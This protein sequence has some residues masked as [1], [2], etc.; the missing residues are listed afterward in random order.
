MTMTSRCSGFAAVSIA[1]LLTAS[2]AGFSAQQDPGSLIRIGDSDLGGVVTSK[3]GPEAGVWVIAETTDLPTK[4]VKI[5]VTDDQGRYVLPELPKANYSVWVRGYGLVD[6]TKAQTAPGRIVNLTAAAAP[7]PAAAA[8]YYPAI[9][10]Y[11]LLKIPDKSVFSGTGSNSNGAPAALKS[12]EQW[13]DIVKTDGCFTCHQIGD[14][15]TRTIPKELGHFES[16]QAAWERRIQSGQAS[17]AMVNAISRLDSNRALA[18]FADWTDRIAA[19]ELP[20]AQPQRPQG[21]ERNVVIS[22]WDWATPT[23][24]LHDEISTD[25]RNPTVNANGPLYGSPEESTDYAP[26]LDPAQNSASQVK[27]PI[28]D[29]NTPSTVDD[30]ILAPS[31]YWGGEPIWNSQANAHNPMFDELGRVWFTSRI[32]PPSNPAFCKEGSG[33]PSAKLFPLESSGRQAAVYDPKTKKFTLIDTCFST[34]HLQFAQD[35][36]NTLW[37]SSGGGG[38]V[39]GWLNRR[40]FDETGD[41]AKSQGWTAL[42]LDANGNG[43][44]DD[45]VEPGEPV[46]PTKDKRIAAAFYGIAPSPADGSVWGSVVGFPGAVA[47]LDLGSDPPATTL[48]EYY[49]LP[50]NDPRAPVHGYSPRGMDIDSNGVVWASLASGHLASFDRRKCKGPLNGPAA[51]GQHCPEGWSLYPFP[52]P[53]FKNVTDS[54]SAEA[55][56]YTWVDQ[57]DTFGLGQ[58]VPIATGNASDALLALVDGKFIILRVPY[59]MGF[60]AKGMDGRIDDKNAGWKGKGL[61]TTYGTRTPFHIEGG[62]G[63]TSKVVRFQL[64]PDPLAR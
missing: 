47:R 34:H 33:N 42:V 1:V 49:E 5:V 62:K 39:V 50:W 43:Q 19:G 16:S 27:L 7:S 52:G 20:A 37:F 23:A 2:S 28:R 8:E 3:N 48:A 45:Y 41:A 38:G 29:P 51:T 60:Y 18:L 22:L 64:R 17:G 46:D 56:Y 54:G 58:N 30:P 31:P 13:L 55:S 11:S 40:A 14:K 9:Y 24:Y 10:W 15:A 25:K 26:I 61:W 4:F 57:H 59:P 63:T 53:Q 36:N 35:V 32:R 21:V 6:S 12:Q 44:R